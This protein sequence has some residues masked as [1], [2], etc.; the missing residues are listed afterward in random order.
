MGLANLPKA[1]WRSANDKEPLNEADLIDIE[2]GIIESLGLAAMPGLIY[3]DATAVKAPA[4]ADNP[5]R[6]VLNGFPDILH[7][8]QLFTA[9]LS[10]GK[11]RENTVD[12]VMDFDL[13]ADRWGTE[14][15][16]QWY[17]VLALAGDADAVFTLKSMPYLRVKSQSVQTISLGTHVTPATGIGYGWDTDSLA[18][19]K[20]YVLTGAS[21]GLLRE[22]TANNNDNSTGGTITYSGDALTL[23]A[24]DWLIVLPATNFRRLGDIFNN[25]SS[26]IEMDDVLFGAYRYIEANSYAVCPLTK[27]YFLPYLI[28]GGGSGDGSTY[29]GYHGARVFP[30]MKLPAVA[31]TV[32]AVT[33]GAGAAAPHGAGSPTS[34]GALITANGGAAD[35]PVGSYD[36]TGW[37]ES[38]VVKGQGWYGSGTPGVVVLF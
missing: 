30:V 27:D 21:K 17:A 25:G 14:K 29:R 35:A 4:T 23:A 6:L 11:Y 19:A 22:I 12:A 9:G 33:I 15:A 10:D 24:G 31:G 34:I 36:L 13:A 20:I 37:P 7:L 18:G 32:Y 1:K 16:N 2:D 5:A 28:G 8:G 26:N 3:V 38:P